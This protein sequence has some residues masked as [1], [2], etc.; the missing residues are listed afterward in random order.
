[1]SNWWEYNFT[2]I[3][4]AAVPIMSN[5]FMKKLNE[6]R[7]KKKLCDVKLKNRISTA[8]KKIKSNWM[9]VETKK[10][11]FIHT[12]THVETKHSTIYFFLYFFLFLILEKLLSCTEFLNPTRLRSLT[13]THSYAHKSLFSRLLLCFYCFLLAAWF[14]C[15]FSFFSR[16]F[17]TFSMFFL[18]SHHIEFSFYFFNLCLRICSM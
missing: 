6:R 13:H 15:C 12:V 9:E 7:I 1:M 17:F 5:R 10:N 11:H 14:C 18:S 2:Y 4:V 8:T 16:F 3:L